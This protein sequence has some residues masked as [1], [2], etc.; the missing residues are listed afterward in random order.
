MAEEWMAK[1]CRAIAYGAD[2]RLFADGLKSGIDAVRKIARPS[3]G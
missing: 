2:H 1:G 3:R